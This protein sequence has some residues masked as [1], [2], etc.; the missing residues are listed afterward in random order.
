MK[1]RAVGNEKSCRSEKKRLHRALVAHVSAPP[2]VPPE[3]MNV[4]ADNNNIPRDQPTMFHLDQIAE[5]SRM[6]LPAPSVLAVLLYHVSRNDE[7]LVY[8]DT[9]IDLHKLCQIQVP[10]L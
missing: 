2:P 9:I 7:A 6:P 8:M 4:F 3:V 10:G 5:V 1:S